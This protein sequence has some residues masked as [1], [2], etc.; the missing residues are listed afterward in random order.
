MNLYCIECLVFTEKNTIKIKR[1]INKKKKKKK[2]DLFSRYI[3][4]GFKGFETI[5]KNILVIY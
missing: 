4:C 5:E 3:D 2:T 1:W